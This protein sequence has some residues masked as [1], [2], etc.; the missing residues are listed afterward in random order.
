MLITIDKMLITLIKM[1]I[2]IDKM[3]IT[4]IK[5]LITGIALLISCENSVENF[6]LV[7]NFGTGNERKNGDY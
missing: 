5:M 7:N 1:L 3:L 6:L 2:T 4:L